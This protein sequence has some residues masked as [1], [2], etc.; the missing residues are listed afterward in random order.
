VSRRARLAVRSEPAPLYSA[1]E[2]TTIDAALAI[3]A[4]RLRS[5]GV[6]L[7]EPQAASDYC[8]LRLGALEHEV[9]AVLF[10]DSRHRVICFEEIFRGTIDGSE[11]H[12]R[13]VVKRALE[14]NA[15]A[16]IMTHNHPSGSLEFS[17]ADRAVTARL[18]QAL[19][20]VEVRVLDHILVAA[21]G[22]QSLA[23]H[24]GL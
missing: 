13:E 2:Q 8:R 6:A 19:A 4:K 3:I 22:T 21:G 18:K 23:R 16:L 10:L 14:L 20:L 15:A 24:G 7:T 1:T 17:A 11:V 9:F 5:T 12:P